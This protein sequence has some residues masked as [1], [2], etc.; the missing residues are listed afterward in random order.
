MGIGKRTAS[1]ASSASTAAAAAAVTRGG[2]ATAALAPAAKPR[3]Q[4]VG[5]CP[6][7]ASDGVTLCRELAASCESGGPRDQ[8]RAR[9]SGC[10]HAPTHPA[11]AGCVGRTRGARSRA[12]D[13]HQRAHRCEEHTARAADG[14]WCV[15]DQA[16]RSILRRSHSPREGQSGDASAW[17]GPQLF[18]RPARPLSQRH[19]RRRHGSGAVVGARPG[20]GCGGASPRSQHRERKHCSG[21]TLSLASHT[22]WLP[23]SLPS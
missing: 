21:L 19:V 15:R 16:A 12:R 18:G 2:L 7:A 3:C 6:V 1:A 5:V 13:T 8:R 14:S 22:C 10:T 11:Q 4:V 20:D 23:V 9:Q 17:Q